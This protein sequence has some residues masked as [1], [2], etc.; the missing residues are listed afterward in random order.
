MISY[1]ET[2]LLQR[3]LEPWQ[4]HV[5]CFQ[6]INQTYQSLII[7]EAVSCTVSEL[8]P[9]TGL[10]QLYLATLLAFNLRRRG[11]PVRSPSILHAGQGWIWFKMASR[12]CRKFQPAEQDAVHD[13][14]RRRRQ[15]DLQLH[16]PECNVVRSDKKL[17]ADVAVITLLGKLFHMLTTLLKNE[18]FRTV[19]SFNN[20]FLTMPS[21]SR[22]QYLY[23]YV[24]CW[25]V[26]V[27]FIC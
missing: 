1:Q 22:Y 9:Q 17:F 3:S 8:Q 18:Y 21:C 11:S 15:T 23:S 14:Y 24:P 6:T 5:C 4:W 20:K 7:H 10:T 12:H 27:I 19:T 25:L 13:W 2:C 16:I 26:I